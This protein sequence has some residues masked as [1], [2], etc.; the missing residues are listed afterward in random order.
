MYQSRR[1]LFIFINRNNFS[2]RAI[3]CA[4]SVLAI[5]EENMKTHMS[6]NNVVPQEPLGD[7]KSIV[8]SVLTETNYSEARAARMDINDFLSLLSA[9]NS[10]GIHFS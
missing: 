7:I 4:K 9:F 10:K 6:V 3:L 1:E 2:A 8:E 5:L